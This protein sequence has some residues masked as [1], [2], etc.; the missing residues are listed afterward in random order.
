MRIEAIW[1][2]HQV[3]KSSR[4]MAFLQHEEEG[5]DGNPFKWWNPEAC[6]K[7]ACSVSGEAGK[8]MEKALQEEDQDS[9]CAKGRVEV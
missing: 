2:G 8:L 6:G 4:R 3:R 9:A 1:R 5:Q 7:P